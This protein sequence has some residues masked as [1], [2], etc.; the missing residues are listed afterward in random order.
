MILTMDIGNTNI[1]CALFEGMEARHYWRIS[2]DVNKTHDEYGIVLTMLMQSA[3]VSPSQVTGIIV[4][5]VV[6]SVNFTLEHML[7]EY[8][9]GVTPI[10]VVPGI[11]TGIHIKYES[12]RDLGADRIANAVGAFECYGGPTIFIDFGTATTYGVISAQAEF[13]GGVICPGVQL[14]T[15]ALYEH[16]AKLPRIELIKPP[17]V[18]NRS[19]VTNMQA[20]IVYGY[21]GM[22]EYLVRKIKA[23]IA[24]PRTRVVATGGLGRIVAAE[25]NCIDIIDGQLTLKGLRLLYERNRPGEGDTKEEA[26]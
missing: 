15:R 9:Q 8:F 7:E 23:E 25:T 14:A 12:P 22:V 26:V 16:T 1:K 19:T 24:D 18:I 17:T 20:G 2:T 21:V 11:K 5:S 13:L 4:S 10:H 3:G 6:P